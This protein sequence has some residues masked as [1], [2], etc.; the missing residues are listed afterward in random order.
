MPHKL[1]IVNFL[2]YDHY[3]LKMPCPLHL[4]ILK[5]IFLYD[6]IDLNIYLFILALFSLYLFSFVVFP[7]FKVKFALEHSTCSFRYINYKLNFGG[8]YLLLLWITQ[9]LQYQK[10]TWG[11]KYYLS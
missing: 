3:V 5:M 10:A 7:Q 4:F 2:L 8:I 11:W 9:W 1:L 6:F